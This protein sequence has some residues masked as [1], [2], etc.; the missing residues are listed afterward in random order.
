MNLGTIS[1]FPHVVTPVWQQCRYQIDTT[2]LCPCNKAPPYW[3]IGYV[4]PPTEEV[5][6]FWDMAQSDFVLYKKA[7]PA[8]SSACE[9]LNGI[10][11]LEIPC[12]Q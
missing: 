12:G 11:L 9:T 8:S 3:P 6:A 2:V 5:G 10:L 4:F 1:E 7:S